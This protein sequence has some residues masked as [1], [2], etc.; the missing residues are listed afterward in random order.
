[1][2]YKQIVAHM[3]DLQPGEEDVLHM[4]GQFYQVR[5]MDLDDIEAVKESIKGVANE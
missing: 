1:M 2:N 3:L 5:R 4:N